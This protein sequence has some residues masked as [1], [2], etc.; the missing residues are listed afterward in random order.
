[1]G[2]RLLYFRL[3]L[4]PLIALPCAALAQPFFKT[5]VMKTDTL[6]VDTLRADA[7][8][9]ETDVFLRVRVR[10]VSVSPAPPPPALTYKVYPSLALSQAAFKDWIEG[11]ANSIAGTATLGAE[12]GYDDKKFIWNAR[13][14]AAFG[15]ARFD[16]TDFRKTVDNLEVQTKVRYNISSD[17]Y[18]QLLST[19]RTQFASGFDYSVQPTK[20]IS[21]F[22]DPAYLVQSFGL[23]YYRSDSLNAS[24]GIAFREIITGRFNTFSDK[25]ETPDVIERINFN[26]G[27][28]FNAVWLVDVFPKVSFRTHLQTFSAF[29]RL[30]VWD[31]RSKNTL[32]FVINEVLF[33]QLSLTVVYQEILSKRVQIQETLAL[34]VG[35]LFKN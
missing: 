25:P 32:R 18:P 9:L 7:D 16:T 20:Q 1:M 3:F 13:F 33:T 28:D 6:K 8:T 29:D 19:V 17:F 23:S 22:F 31:V 27:I 15:L 34:N 35:Y 14:D 12:I 24:L 30:Q 2:N 4:L 11:G 26:T 10:R 5:E 21:A